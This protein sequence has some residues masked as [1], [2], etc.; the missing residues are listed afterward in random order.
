M[1]GGATSSQEWAWAQAHARSPLTFPRDRRVRAQEHGALK[2]NAWLQFPGRT[3]KLVTL[4][5]LPLGLSKTGMLITMS[6]PHGIDLN[7]NKLTYLKS[8]EQCQVHS[9]CSAVTPEFQSVNWQK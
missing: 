8:L 3:E 4:G 1:G 5:K 7:V 2:P 9:R 6:L